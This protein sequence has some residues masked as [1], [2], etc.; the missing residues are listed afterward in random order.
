MPDAFSQPEKVKIFN[1]ADGKVEEVEKVYKTDAQ[2]KKVLTPEQYWVTRLKGTEK[3][4]SPGCILPKKNETGVF[5][6]VGC[7]T[8]LFIVETKFESGTGWPSFWEPVSALNIREV[9]DN[10]FGMHRTE[11]VCARCDAH[12]GHVFDDGPPPTGKRYCMNGAALKFKKIDSVKVNSLEKA[13]FAAGCFWGVQAA[14]QE[15]KGVITATAGYAGGSTR[16]PAYEVVCTGKT[17]H[18]ETVEVEFD[19]AV[20]S[21]ESLLDLFFNI[22][23]PT[24]LNRQGADIGSQYRSVIFYYTPQQKKI[25][26]AAKEKLE[27]SVRYQSPVVTEIVEAKD[28]YPAEGYHQDYY[29]KHNLKPLCH[30]PKPA[31]KQK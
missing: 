22:H 13:A 6:C 30:I 15:V 24:A 7:G 9:A 28:F 23:D 18:A 3:P 16:N 21:Y 29:K 1:S 5:Q 19:P 31:N 10:S 25:A 20:V 4:F 12:L 26:L 27:H 11:V 2:W 8:D 17:G 14:F